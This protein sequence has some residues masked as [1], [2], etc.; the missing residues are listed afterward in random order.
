MILKFSL[1]EMSF[2]ILSHDSMLK[3]QAIAAQESL[4]VDD[5]MCIT[6]PAQSKQQCLSAYHLVQ[7]FLEIYNNVF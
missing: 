1:R 7:L 6:R 2:V 5:L 3:V 4:L